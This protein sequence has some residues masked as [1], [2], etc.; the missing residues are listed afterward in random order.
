MA[1]SHNIV[2]EAHKIIKS[3]VIVAVRRVEAQANHVFTG[4]G[5]VSEEILQTIR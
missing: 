5:D 4:N 2:R 1:T 3:T